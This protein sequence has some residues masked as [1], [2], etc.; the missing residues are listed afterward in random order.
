MSV[1][2]E[3]DSTAEKL[4]CQI[5]DHRSPRKEIRYGLQ[6][7]LD[8]YLPCAAVYLCILKTPYD[9][10]D[11]QICV[12][13]TATKFRSKTGVISGSAVIVIQ[14][15]RFLVLPSYRIQ[16]HILSAD[17]AYHC[18]THSV[19]STT[20]R[21]NPFRAV[22]LETWPKRADTTHPCLVAF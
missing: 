15:C 7:H 18:R 11:R 20:R 9:V 4:S 21:T 2:D 19:A 8:T 1:T 22:E 13:D 5:T 6:L 16:S 12:L 3:G 17:I 14:H 10:N